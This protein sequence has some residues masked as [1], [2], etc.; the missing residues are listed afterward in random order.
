M[1]VD[2]SVWINHFRRANRVLSAALERGDVECHDFIIG[3]LA[4][5]TLSQRADVLT[6]MHTL[7]R[8]TRVTHTETLALLDERRLWGRGLGWI[9]VSLLA[10][11]FLAPTTLWTHDRPLR[12]VAEDLGVASALA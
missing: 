9:D 7:P 8:V 12:K 2:T 4:C 6:L 3:E 11:A 1:L 10:A 5:G